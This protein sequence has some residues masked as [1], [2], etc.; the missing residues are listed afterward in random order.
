MTFVGRNLIRITTTFF[1]FMR[2]GSLTLQWIYNHQLFLLLF[3]I[4]SFLCYSP[5]I[6]VKYIA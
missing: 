6:S 5:N 4:T 2:H 3:N 1:L